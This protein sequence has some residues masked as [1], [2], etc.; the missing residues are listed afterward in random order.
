M[1]LKSAK[2]AMDGQ[3]EIAVRMVA[4]YGHDPVEEFSKMSWTLDGIVTAVIYDT[5]VESNLYKKAGEYKRQLWDRYWR[6][7]AVE[8]ALNRKTLAEI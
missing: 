6:E 3:Y 8:E 7:D 5:P 1:T 2:K 4:K